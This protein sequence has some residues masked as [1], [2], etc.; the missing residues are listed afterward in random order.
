MTDIDAEEMTRHNPKY[1]EDHCWSQAVPQPYFY[2]QKQLDG[3]QIK[4]NQDQYRQQVNPMGRKHAHG[5]FG[6]LIHIGCIVYGCKIAYGRY[7]V[8]R[9]RGKYDSDEVGHKKK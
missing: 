1:A 8:G 9:D 6:N 5:Q 2:I 4:N 3:D 7:D